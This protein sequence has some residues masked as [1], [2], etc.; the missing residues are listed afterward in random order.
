MMVEVVQT[1][2][3]EEW[4]S[5]VSQE[6]HILYLSGFVI[7]FFLMTYIKSIAWTG[8]TGRKERSFLPVLLETL[9]RSS[10]YI[11]DVYIY[12]YIPGPSKVPNGWER[13]PLS[14]PLGFKH[15]P[16]EGAGIYL[17]YTYMFYVRLI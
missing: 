1:S 11:V 2:F 6:C 5:Y 15:H 12:I 14:N 13:V 3:S 4:N 9:L 16:L 10:L 8:W 7:Q 17:Q